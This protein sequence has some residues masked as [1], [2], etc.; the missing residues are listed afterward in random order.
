M[1]QSCQCYS[2]KH[3]I[4]A[5][6]TYSSYD[7]LSSVPV[8]DVHTLGVICWQCLIWLQVLIRI[9]KFPPVFSF[10]LPQKTAHS[11]LHSGIYSMSLNFKVFIVRV[12]KVTVL[13]VDSVGKNILLHAVCFIEC[14]RSK[15]VLLDLNKCIFIH[16]VSSVFGKKIEI[17][18]SINW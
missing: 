16:F 13:Q 11:K 17:V 4:T 2:Q 12:Q 1:C 15:Y 14:M 5:R 9:L 10:L 6:C 3:E 8:A 18:F 7:W